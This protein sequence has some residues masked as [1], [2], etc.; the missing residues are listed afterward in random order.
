VQEALTV[1]ACTL[2]LLTAASTRTP[3][4]VVKEWAVPSWRARVSCVLRGSAEG[5]GGRMLNFE[6]ATVFLPV[7]LP[8]PS[9]LL[10]LPAGTDDHHKRERRLVPR[11]V[12]PTAF[13]LT[14]R[15]AAGEGWRTTIRLAPPTVRHGHHRCPAHNPSNLYL[16]P[17]ITHTHT[18]GDT[19][20]HVD[21]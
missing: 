20:R 4:I 2:P 17:H 10:S 18:Y 3:I 11:L 5:R 21:T 13:L 6:E 14:G 19:D 9:P 12:C 16:H 7:F 1:L 15:L 8:P